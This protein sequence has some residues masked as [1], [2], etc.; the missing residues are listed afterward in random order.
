[1]MLL[2]TTL[3]SLFGWAYE[4][5]SELISLHQTNILLVVT[6][7]FHMLSGIVI[8]SFWS[9]LLFV[10]Y[11]VNHEQKDNNTLKRHGPFVAFNFYC[12]IMLISISY[13]YCSVLTNVLTKHN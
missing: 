13:N 9:I 10:G 2:L 5:I 3:D 7:V 12:K 11:C 6:F 1:M 8:C 4:D